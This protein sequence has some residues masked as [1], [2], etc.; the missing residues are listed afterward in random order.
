MTTSDYYSDSAREE[1]SQPV[2]D[3][4]SI[5]QDHSPIIQPVAAPDRA[6]PLTDQ[7]K[8]K[9]SDEVCVCVCV[10]VCV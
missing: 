5:A 2:L 3:H 4:P 7:N 8:E 6:A 10:C 9:K 1:M